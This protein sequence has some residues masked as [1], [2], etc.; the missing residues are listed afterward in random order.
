MKNRLT[1][2]ALVFL[3]LSIC[4]CALGQTDGLQQRIKT[5]RNSKRFAVN[6]DR[7]KDQ[8]RVSVGPFIPKSV[9][10]EA[11]FYF[12]GKQL[13]D[14]ITDAYLMLRS[15]GS[16][17]RFLNNRTLYA[18][19][20]SERINFGE[21]NRVSFIQLGSVSETLIFTVPIETFKKLAHAKSVEFKVSDAEFSL[22]D[23][24]LQAFRDLL[25]LTLTR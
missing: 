19:I 8:T 15:Y 11:R 5:F 1:F 4:P 9:T 14:P 18:I 13:A 25:S 7:F 24:H 10:I 16:D 21:G 2:C 3:A 20:D 23:E 6:Y 12:K 17:W 22:N